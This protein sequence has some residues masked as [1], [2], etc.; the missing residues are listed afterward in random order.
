MDMTGDQASNWEFFKDN[1]KNYA[2]ATK[3]DQKDRKIVS[4][5]L[6]WIMGKECLHV[7]RNLPMT[8]EERQDADVILTK[9][10]EYFVPKRNTIYERYVFNC[11]SQKHGKSF[12]Q[13]LT[14]LREF[15]ATCQFG[16]FED[17]MLRDRIV[18]GLRDQGQ[19]ER[20]LR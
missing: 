15:A 5:T 13:L 7:C 3:L 12:D 10:D 9:L 14:E 8:E 19:S 20:L 11:R 1:W 6:L 17:E 2:T 4:A 16:T 18:T